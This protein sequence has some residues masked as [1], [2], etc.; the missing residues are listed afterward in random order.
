[1]Q[2]RWIAFVAFSSGERSVSRVCFPPDKWDQ[3]KL[4]AWLVHFYG[5][6]TE[7][8]VP[9]VKLPFEFWKEWES[10]GLQKGKTDIIYVSDG[11]ISVPQEVTDKFNKW[12]KDENV[13]VHTIIIESGSKGFDSVSDYLYNVNNIDVENSSVQNVMS[14]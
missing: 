8:N 13:K 14:I 2:K 1:M 9:L 4:L 7:C 12:K 6:G 3:D 10:Q 11:E 5:G